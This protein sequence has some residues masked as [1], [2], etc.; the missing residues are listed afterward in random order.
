MNNKLDN[1]L[2]EIDYMLEKAKEEKETLE[3][4]TSFYK[5]TLGE[6]FALGD[7]KY[8]IEHNNWLHKKEEK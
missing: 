4:G 2:K 1:I 7:L 6:I 3:K 8:S 5:M